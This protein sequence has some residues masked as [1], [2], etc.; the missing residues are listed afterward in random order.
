M[1]IAQI[2]EVWKHDLSGSKQAVALAYADHANE[3]GTG[4]WPSIDR[5][6]WKTGLHR[7][8]VQR[9]LRELCDDGIMVK[10]NEATHR[11]PAEYQ[12]DWSKGKKKPSF[13]EYK[14]GDGPSEKKESNAGSETE[15]GTEETSPSQA[16]GGENQDP[17]P[18][19]EEPKSTSNGSHETGF[20]GGTAPPLLGDFAP[21]QGWHVATS[22]V[23]DNHPRG[24]RLSRQGWQTT[25]PGV[26]QRHPKR[27]IN[28]NETSKQTSLQPSTPH[29]ALTRW[30]GT[31]SAT[32]VDYGL[33]GSVQREETTGV[34]LPRVSAVIAEWLIREMAELDL[35][36]GNTRKAMKRK[37]DRQVIEEVADEIRLLHEQDGYEY[38][39]VYRT[40][41]HTLRP[42]SKWRINRWFQSPFS[43]RQNTRSG[44]KTRFEA[45]RNQF[46]ASSV[47]QNNS[48]PSATNTPGSENERHADDAHARVQQLCQRVQQDL[49]AGG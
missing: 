1:A 7:R 6:A 14:S 47:K 37:P 44:T 30:V 19:A 8:T 23:A 36:S 40:L 42:S 10:V 34:D 28:D 17:D 12:F 27:P 41:V 32:R 9:K 11:R 26:A 46:R 13:E 4:M 35:L 25:T 45:M 39:T 20:G 29:P 33:D 15:S 3:D 22:G 31:P 49:R 48:T 43:L 38:R 24:G 2:L 5:V 21:H 18:P 16:N